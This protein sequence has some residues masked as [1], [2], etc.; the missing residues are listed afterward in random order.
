ML[1]N[2]FRVFEGMFI[3]CDFFLDDFDSG[4]FV[5]LTPDIDES[6]LVESPPKIRDPQVVSS[7][8]EIKAKY[9]DKFTNSFLSMSKGAEVEVF[10]ITFFCPK[11]NE[12]SGGSVLTMVLN[13]IVINEHD[14]IEKIILNRAA[15][16]EEN[17]ER[18]QTDEEFVFVKKVFTEYGRFGNVNLWSIENAGI[19]SSDDL[20]SYVI[21]NSELFLF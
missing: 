13:R 3:W 19:I 5:K 10:G 9:E 11:I 8:L 17:S 20:N 4:R 1:K 15:N 16:E 21:C 12:L 18:E 6:F 14:Q 2:F 7:S